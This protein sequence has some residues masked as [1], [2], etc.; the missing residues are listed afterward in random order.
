MR[1]R[2]ARLDTH[3]TYG[4]AITLGIAA[5]TLGTEEPA[6]S[7][8]IHPAAGTPRWLGVRPIATPP[9]RHRDVMISRISRA[10]SLGVL[11]TCTPTFSSASFFAAAVP[12]EPETIAPACPI[13]L[14]SGA[15]KPATYPT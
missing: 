15:V 10:V 1:R 9:R 14:P 5:S 2:E 4:T 13:V 7:A 6:R 11:P 3:F 8:L 12:D